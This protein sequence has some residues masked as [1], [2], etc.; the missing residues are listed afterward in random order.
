MR[1]RASPAETVMAVVLVA[2]V[3]L[4]AL[5]WRYSLSSYRRRSIA[6]AT[7]AD[8]LILLGLLRNGPVSGSLGPRR[9]AARGRTWLARTRAYLREAGTHQARK[10]GRAARHPTL[11]KNSGRTLL[12][13]VEVASPA[14]C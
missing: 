6:L 2:L 8:P 12:R 4:G 10:H 7:D 11:D 13:P 3:L 14:T 5:A 1:R 9:T